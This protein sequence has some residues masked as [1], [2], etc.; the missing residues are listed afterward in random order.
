MRRVA[1]WV[2]LLA[3]GGVAHASGKH[4]RWEALEGLDPYALVQ[5][6]QTGWA[7]PDR[8][9]VESVTEAAL[10]CIAEGAE[11]GKRLVYPREAVREVEVWEEAPNR[12]IGIWIGLG[13]GFALGG[14]VCAAGGPGPFFACAA[15]GAAI[16][17]GVA[18]SADGPVP[19]GVWWPAPP[20]PPK[21]HRMRW[22]VVYRAPAR[23]AATP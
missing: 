15:L 18:A 7:G 20:P 4:E 22:G 5:V 10:T 6:R 19:F 12:H 8:C 21:R 9:R 1:A 3:M 14:T 2:L 17:V 16:G 13:I 11:Q 23:A